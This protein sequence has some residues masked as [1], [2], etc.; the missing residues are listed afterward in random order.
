MNPLEFV[1]AVSDTIGKIDEYTNRDAFASLRMK[2][3][4]YLHLQMLTFVSY[5][6]YHG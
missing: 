2:T 1:N 3:A 6:F 5:V 4:T